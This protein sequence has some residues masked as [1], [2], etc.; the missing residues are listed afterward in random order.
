MPEGMPEAEMDQ[1]TGLGD[2][3]LV[4]V[5]EDDPIARNILTGILAGEGCVVIEAEDGVAGLALMRERRPHLVFL[6]I[7]LPRLSGF[8]VCLA[9]RRDPELASI[10]ILMVTSLA[11]K[12]DIVKGL[13]SGANDYVTKPYNP[14]ELLARAQVNLDRKRLLDRIVE[15]NKRLQ[16]AYEVLEATTSSLD[17]RQVL[18]IL[19]ERSARSLGSDRCSIIVIDDGDGD[20]DGKGALPRGRVLVSHEDPNFSELSIDLAKYPEVVKAWRTG[21]PVQVDDAGTDPLM[22]EVRG[23]FDAIGFRSLLALP[24]SY[25]GEVMGALL[26]RSFRHGSTYSEEEITLARII[27]SASA[28]ALKNAGLYSA[29]DARSEGLG[30][31]NSQLL[32]VNEELSRLHKIKNEFLSMVSHELRTPLTTIIGF[33]ELL[34]EEQVGPLTPKQKEFSHQIFLKGRTLLA[35]I[36]DLLETGKIEAGKLVARHRPLK[37]KELLVA[38]VNANRYTSTTPREFVIEVPSDLPEVEADPDKVA[39]VLANLIG[40]AAKFSP[41][42]SPITVSACRLSGRRGSDRGDF[43][44][45]SVTDLGVGI[46]PDHQGRVFEQ[47]YQIEQGTS[48]GYG[49][50]GLGLHIAKALVELHGGRIWVES[51]VGKG[52]TFHF[53]LPVKQG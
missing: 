47:F 8:E 18:Y 42:G 32:A 23:A 6:D 41:E 38:A 36:N 53:T 1:R 45:L 35:M 20:G 48:R 13:K 44:R 4:L 10:P 31:A 52:S 19:V 33:S 37:V 22:S 43:I 21:K 16:L 27:A 17:L 11:K 25:R 40:N 39:Q 30:K 50:T 15:Q 46:A 9:A 51:A 49:G 26:L 24:L 14:V 5:V 2:Q 28:N 34:Q 7:V 3:A 29:L 12:E